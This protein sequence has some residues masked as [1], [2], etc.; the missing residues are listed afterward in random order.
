MKRRF[1]LVFKTDGSNIQNTVVNNIIAMI[2]KVITTTNL[3]AE[4][5]KWSLK[6]K[7]KEK[8]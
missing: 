3:T 2:N 6:V 5:E 7:L 1:N 8:I 4:K